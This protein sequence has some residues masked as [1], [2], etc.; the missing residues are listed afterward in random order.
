MKAIAITPGKGN[1]HIMDI[2]EP[3]IKSEHDVKIEVLEVGIC[4]TDREEASGGRA[5]PPEGQNELVIGHEMVGRVV[6]T[7]KAVTRVK[8][9]D[10]ALFMV[11]RPCGHCLFCTNGRSDMCLSG[12]YKERGIK[13]LQG[14]Q[15]EYAVDL[16]DYVI[17]VPAEISDIAVLTEPMSVVVKAIE[18]SLH[19]QSA[20]FSGIYSHDWLNGKKV[21]IAGLGSVGLL[22]AFVVKLRGA[23]IYG[24]DIVDESSIRPSI[25]KEIGGTY[26][27]GKGMGTEVIDTKYGEMDFIVEAT[28]IAKLELD[29]IDALGINGIYVLIGIPFGDR[30][31][32][33]S[34]AE[35]MKQMVLKNQILLGSVNAGH[36]HYLQA[37]DEL[38][39]IKKSFGR[40]I[41]RMITE[42]VPYER[43][44][45][46]LALHSPDEIKTIV[47]WKK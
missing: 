29:L 19:L 22:A 45:E 42:R 32:T 43:F 7:G 36:N 1:A 21:L 40:T 30:P 2:V 28:G 6:E 9:D 14:F 8:K 10:Y 46:V 34:G 41:S 35:L 5:D 15:S 38:V 33:V 26:I 4:G 25:L 31:V 12:D 11:R 23:E 13:G 3:V 39:K 17:P 44:N 47:E 37:V 27:N 16:E 18:E 24:L 20:R